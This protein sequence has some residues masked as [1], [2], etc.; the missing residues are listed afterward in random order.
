MRIEKKNYYRLVPRFSRFQV[1]R[2]CSW[3]TLSNDNFILEENEYK[4][5][6]TLIKEFVVYILLVNVIDN[7]HF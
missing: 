4:W 7:F 1:Y 2:N 6:N 3:S 5:I